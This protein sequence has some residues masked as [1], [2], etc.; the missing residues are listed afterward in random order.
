M[1]ALPKTGAALPKS[2]DEYVN[3]RELSSA[4]QAG[5]FYRLQVAGM[6]SDCPS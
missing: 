1:K 5:T 2:E 4:E 3:F 6:R